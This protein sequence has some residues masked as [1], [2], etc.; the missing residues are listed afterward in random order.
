M[1]I[2][3]EQ[4]EIL[5]KFRKRKRC[6]SEDSEF[7]REIFKELEQIRK[8]EAMT[9]PAVANFIGNIE[10]FTTGDDF[11][12]YIERWD[13][14]SVINKTPENE[15]VSLLIGLGGADLFRIIKLVAA[16]KKPSE[17]TYNELKKALKNYFEP[18]RNIIGER[19][20]FHRRQ[21]NADENVCDYI[22]EIKSLSQTC[23]FGTF[24]E[25]ALRD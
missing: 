6:E 21:Q 19:F 23:E 17:F 3:H 14:V 12:D 24:L 7:E 1:S 22:I 16:P 11:Q 4:S 10:H 18:K 5:L 25:D 8:R 15:K 13:H 20:I 2:N 9:P